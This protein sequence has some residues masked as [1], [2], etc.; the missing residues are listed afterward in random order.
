MKVSELIDILKRHDPSA[1]VVVGSKSYLP[2]PYS[3]L[4]EYFH[5]GVNE[6]KGQLGA[7]G[8]PTI[9]VLE[10]TDEVVGYF[11]PFKPLK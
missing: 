10:M 1:D 6:H 3:R 2:K 5:F 4:P 7:K 9:L 11:K 8:S